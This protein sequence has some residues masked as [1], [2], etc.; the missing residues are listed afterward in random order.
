MVRLVLKINIDA[1]ESKPNNQKEAQESMFPSASIVQKIY[2]G[3]LARRLRWS[4]YGIS[5]QHFS[6]KKGSPNL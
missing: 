6:L 5:E 3:S 4:S 2:Q 1:G